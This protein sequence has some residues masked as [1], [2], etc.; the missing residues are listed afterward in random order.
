MYTGSKCIKTR[1]RPGLHPEPCWGS[2]RRSPT[3]RRL[4][5][6]P[7]PHTLPPS[8]HSASRCLRINGA[9]VLGPHQLQV[10]DTLMS[11]GRRGP[12][13]F[14]CRGARNLKFRHCAAALKISSSH[15]AGQQIRGAYPG[16][17]MGWITPIK[18]YRGKSIFL[19]SPQQNND[20]KHQNLQ[21]CM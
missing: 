6:F 3:P 19:L 8:R 12:K 9:S 18:K 1:F 13:W 4:G 21:I 7:H 16:G 15:S 14:S 11:L 17:M 10:L 20:K 5:R 2:L